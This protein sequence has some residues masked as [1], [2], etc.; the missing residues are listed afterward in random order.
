MMEGLLRT[1]LH[2]AATAMSFCGQRWQ[3]SR[4]RSI[5]QRTAGAHQRA[6]IARRPGLRPDLDRAGRAE[7]HGTRIARADWP[8]H[9]HDD[10]NWC[11]RDVGCHAEGCLRAV[12]LRLHIPPGAGAAAG[13][14]RRPVTHGL[15][16]AAARRGHCLPV[17]VPVG[18]PGAGLGKAPGQ[19]QKW[20]RDRVGRNIGL[21]ARRSAEA[22]PGAS[23]TLAP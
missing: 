15:G 22:R 2:A 9:L 23:E 18:P 8:G 21:E 5:S 3:D 12:E 7:R 11:L 6:Q 14:G 19:T 13:T 4:G 17:K 10:S 1:A 20:L 16:A